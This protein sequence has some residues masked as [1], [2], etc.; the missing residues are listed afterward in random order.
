MKIIKFIEDLDSSEVYREF[1]RQAFRKGFPETKTTE[2]DLVKTAA[3]KL[4]QENE[5]NQKADLTPS[6]SLNQDIARLIIAMKLKGLVSQADDIEQNFVMFKQAE[7]NLYNLNL[8]ENGNILDFAH[9]DGDVN[10]IE[11]SGELGAIETPQSAAE[12]ILAVVRKTP[13]GKAPSKEASLRVIASLIKDSQISGAKESIMAPIYRKVNDKIDEFPNITGLN[14]SFTGQNFQTNRNSRLLYS[15]VTDIPDAVVKKAADM[16]RWMLARGF[17]KIDH[18][19]FLNLIRNNMND[20]TP[21]RE[22]ATQLRQEV[23]SLNGVSAY[24]AGPNGQLFTDRKGDVSTLVQLNP[25]SIYIQVV[26]VYGVG[27][28]L[29][30]KHKGWQLNEQAAHAYAEKLRQA[31]YTIWSDPAYGKNWATLT[32][33][34]AKVNQLPE[35]LYH[36]VL[37]SKVQDPGDVTDEDGDVDSKKSL[38]PIYNSQRSIYNL[39]E[40]EEGKQAVAAL[41]YL[42]DIG[43]GKAVR[44]WSKRMNDVYKR[45]EAKVVERAGTSMVDISPAVK[46]M[47]SAIGHLTKAV[48][49]LPKKSDAR[50]E[51]RER[52]STIEGLIGSLLS[53]GSRDNMSKS[54]DELRDILEENGYRDFNDL[55]TSLDEVEA[56]AKSDK[57]RAV[58]ISREI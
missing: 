55:L 15:S 20:A 5:A 27:D 18:T 37:N 30:Y 51:A 28:N 21:V 34:N 25:R 3:L 45:A 13:S 42:S 23:N 47:R 40:S 31:Y 26:R 35:T 29:R 17:N 58:Q 48:D 33:A 57:E 9:R 7:N 50:R 4:S 32:A 52:I 11:G 44:A 36:N 49:I 14:L 12:K 53:I 38:V 6:D 41:D 56:S 1:E 46:K 19:E 8:D 39:L 16:Y 24:R 54:S 22:V 2:Q 10:I 43:L